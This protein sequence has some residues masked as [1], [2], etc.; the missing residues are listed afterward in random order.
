[1]KQHNAYVVFKRPLLCCLATSSSRTFSRKRK[2]PLMKH[3]DMNVKKYC[4]L[5]ILKQCQYKALSGKSC[6]GT[7]IKFILFYDTTFV[8]DN[9]ITITKK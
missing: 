7:L 4:A 8:I 3:S 5:N 9:I 6:P 2:I 1:M